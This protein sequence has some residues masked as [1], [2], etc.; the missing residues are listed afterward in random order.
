M[1]KSNKFSQNAT[2]DHYLTVVKLG[3]VPFPYTYEHETV[4]VHDAGGAETEHL[5]PIRVPNAETER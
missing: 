3:L 5:Y 2:D 4:M 1:R